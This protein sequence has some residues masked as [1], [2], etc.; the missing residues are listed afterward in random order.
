M[1]RTGALG[2]LVLL[3]SAL[4]AAPAAAQALE[5]R[6]ELNSVAVVHG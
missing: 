1:L 2:S 6:L 3:L 4:G 5:H